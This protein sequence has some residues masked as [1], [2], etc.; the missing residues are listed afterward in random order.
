MLKGNGGDE[1]AGQLPNGRPTSPETAKGREGT[2]ASRR[3]RHSPGRRGGGS[4]GEVV[5]GTDARKGRLCNS[6]GNHGVFTSGVRGQPGLDWTH[7]SC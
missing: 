2:G 5:G 7:R 1:G 6:Q 4:P 3:G